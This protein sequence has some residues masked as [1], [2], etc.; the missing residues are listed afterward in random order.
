VG[1]QSSSRLKGDDYQHLY[2]WFELLQ[3]LGTDSL[4]SYG[5]V[6]HPT[7]G[8][9][10]D[11]TLHS[12]NNALAKYTQ[13]KFHVDQQSQYSSA[14]V[15]EVPPGSKRSILHKLF[16]SWKALRAKGQEAAT[17]ARRKIIGQIRDHG[18]AQ[19][20]SRSS[21]LANGLRQA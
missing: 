8:A 21:V 18:A 20:G 17:V 3:L 4:Y 1:E 10:D 12:D 9:A 6:E 7:A 11:I 15:V 14:S 16:D 2:S 19:I 5:F 13:V